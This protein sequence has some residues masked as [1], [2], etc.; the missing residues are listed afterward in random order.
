MSW[1]FSS[2]NGS[3]RGPTA[4]P[5]TK[6]QVRRMSPEQVP[7]AVQPGVHP[8]RAYRIRSGLMADALD[9]PELVA[10]VADPDHMRGA[11]ISG[12]PGASDRSGGCGDTGDKKS[13]LCSTLCRNVVMSKLSAESYDETVGL[14][15]RKR[16]QGGLEH[17]A[18]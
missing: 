12:E 5:P 2:E 6:P 3:L 14:R 18:A 16:A 9:R 10:V 1:I 15:R 11:A 8:P 7:A 4:G 13:A 17:S